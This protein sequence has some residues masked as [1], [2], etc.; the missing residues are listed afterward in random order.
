[1]TILN[2]ESFPTSSEIKVKNF[3]GEYEVYNSNTVIRL[4]IHRLHRADVIIRLSTEGFNAMETM[5]SV[6]F[7][8]FRDYLIPA[9]GFQSLQLREIEIILGLKEK[10]RH[11]L[12]GQSYLN[13]FKTD[14]VDFTNILNELS[15]QPSLKET[16]YSCLAKLNLPRRDEFAESF[17]EQKKVQFDLKISNLEKERET[18]K[19][20]IEKL[21]HISDDDI[22]QAVKQIMNSP[23]DK[24][25][26]ILSQL[27]PFFI[28]SDR[29][30][31]IVQSL[32]SNTL[33][34]TIKSWR[35]DDIKTYNNVIDHF[36]KLIKATEEESHNL[37]SFFNSSEYITEKNTV[38]KKYTF[39]ECRRAA[40]YIM[41]HPWSQYIKNEEIEVIVWSQLINTFLKLEQALL[42]W[43]NRHARMVELMIGN[44]QGTG[45]TSGIQY[46]DSTQDYRVYHDLWHIR[47]HLISSSSNK[48]WKEQ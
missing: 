34:E 20:Y 41:S 13:Q 35:E 17:L 23:K 12:N 33:S 11:L 28:K 40:L 9:S 14:K 2:E 22:Q 42:L 8:E 39:G 3:K 7:L 43:R 45:G 21:T 5:E 26:N 1:M 37:A 16:F 48:Y 30:D 27:G 46:L 36:D 18:H 19:N 15:S 32:E 10:E 4:L 38:G 47:S 25:S 6:D 44:R 29:I 31:G 24:F